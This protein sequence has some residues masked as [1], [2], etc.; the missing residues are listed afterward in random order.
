MNLLAYFMGFIFGGLVAFLCTYH[1]F[2]L[3]DKTCPDDPSPTIRNIL[4]VDSLTAY[5][6]YKHCINN[7]VAYPAIVT[8]QSIQESGWD[9]ES[10]NATDRNN[11]LGIGGADPMTFDHWQDCI[12]YYRD[13]IQSRYT[14]G[15]YYEFLER[16]GY[17]SDSAYCDKVRSIVNKIIDL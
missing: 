4:T 14:G 10:Y 7:G 6:V 1:H 8:A 16:I 12:D 2:D 17:A 9:Y 15:D 11:I 3:K 13:R 5:N